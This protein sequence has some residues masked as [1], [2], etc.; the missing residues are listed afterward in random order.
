SSSQVTLIGHNQLNNV[1]VFNT[2]IVVKSSGAVTQTLSTKSRADFKLQ[3]PFGHN[4]EVYFQNA[5]G[6]VM[7]MEVIANTVPSD[8][9]QYMMTYEMNVPFVSKRDEDVDTSVFTKPFYRIF[10]NGSNRMVDD[11][12]YNNKFAASI[13]KRFDHYGKLEGRDGNEKYAVVLSGKILASA[14][15]SVNIFDKPIKLISKS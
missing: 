9:Y 10:Y 6:P 5:V 15:N 13:I 7:F 1:A 14:D 11:S 4:Y 8:K 2:R 3:L 12:A